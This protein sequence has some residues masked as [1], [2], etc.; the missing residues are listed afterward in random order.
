MIKVKFEFKSLILKVSG[1]YY[2]K[3]LKSG[4]VETSSFLVEEKC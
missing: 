3:E 1:R 2:S 4:D